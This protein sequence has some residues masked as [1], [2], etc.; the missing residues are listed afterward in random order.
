MDLYSILEAANDAG[1]YLYLE[2]GSLKFKA[3][4]D[5]FPEE[6]RKDITDN[7]EAII[8][9]LSQLEEQSGVAVQLSR[10]DRRGGKELFTLSSPQERL[11]TLAQLS[12]LG[13]SYNISS[14]LIW[15]GLFDINKFNQSIQMLIERHEIIRT[16]YVEDE[17]GVPWQVVRA[18]T[19]F[20][21]IITD[22]SMFK[23][24]EQQAQLLVSLEHEQIHEFDLKTGLMLRVAV[25][26]KHEFEHIVV[27]TMHHIASDGWSMEIARREIM[28]CYIALMN[29]KRP[30]LP[31]LPIQY[32]DYASWQ[33][34]LKESSAFDG[35]LA[36]WRE[37]LNEAPS[38]HSIQ[39]DYP[40]PTEKRYHGASVDYT[41]TGEVASRLS[42]LSQ[43]LQI[44][45]FMLLHAALGIVFSRHSNSSDII[46][47]TPV[48]GREH[49]NL[50]TLVGFFIN[51]L[52]L[53]IS[54]DYQSF[55]DYIGHVKK[56]H[57]DAH[58]NQDIPFESLV[59]AFSVKRTPSYMPIFQIML[60]TGIE[61]DQKQGLPNG[62]DISPF[63]LN[64]VHCKYDL[65]IYLSIGEDAVDMV[66]NYDISLFTEERVNKLALHL[67]NVLEDWS[68]LSDL[69]K[70]SLPDLTILSESERHFLINEFNDTGRYTPPD[71]CI[72]HLFEKQVAKTPGQI[73][74]KTDERQMTY[75]ELNRHAN[76]IARLLKE[77]HGVGP[78]CVVG[79]YAERSLEMVI[80][81]IA[82]LK[83]GGA[84]LPLDP[85]YPV[86]RLKFILEDAAL[87]IIVTANASLKLPFDFL[88]DV[89]SVESGIEKGVQGVSSKAY[90]DENLLAA[91]LSL[92]P[93]HLAYVIY[94]SGSTGQPKGVMVEHQAIVNRI[95]WMHQ[96]YGMCCCDKVLQKTPYSFDVSVWEFLWTLG[97]G[98]QLIMARPSG[99]K[100]PEYLCRLIQ[101]EGITK[102][103]FVPSMLGLILE[104]PQFSA[105]TSLQQVFCSGET[106]T[107][108][109]VEA[110]YRA[111]P[112]TQLYNLYGPT[113][114]AIDVSS[115]DCSDNN[116]TSVPIGK[117]IDN[118]QLFIL[119]DNMQLVPQGTVGELYIG[120]DGLARGYLNRK[121][122]TEKRFVDN[123]FY[124]EALHA[125]S[126]RL[127]RTGD[128]V[129]MRADGA[130]EY[131]GRTD[132]QIKIRGLR[133]ELGEIEYHLEQLPNVDSAQVIAREKYDSYQIIAYVGFESV[134][135]DENTQTQWR[136]TLAQ[137]LPEHMLPQHFV[138]MDEWPRTPNGK[139]D[140]K[141]L[142]E[143]VAAS[144]EVMTLPKTGTE[145]V[146]KNIWCDLLDLEAEQLS[147]DSNFFELGGHSLLGMRMLSL[148]NKRFSIEISVKEILRYQDIVSLGGLIDE[149]C[150]LAVENNERG[151]E[152]QEY[153][154]F[155]L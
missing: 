15:R 35:Q 44:T 116:N 85:E 16:N 40:R 77:Q 143:P 1:I 101:Q 122:L 128:L 119:N 3:R 150:M 65:E 42:R 102:L 152:E 98:G 62:Y 125:K 100:E 90:S 19:P 9:L 20:Q 46:V 130:I 51:N 114:A 47:G 24:T 39:L 55:L 110:F 2:Q 136:K 140:R 132:H 30:N 131:L 28:E 88:G 105:C 153:E 104:S 45:P 49:A 57:L 108:T 151:S 75:Q 148:V 36:Y 64:G 34:K 126:T 58:K 127:Y 71:L 113:E 80:G 69:T 89:V 155:S 124:Q 82:I 60:H 43:R 50:Q 37:Q 76:R 29:D 141:A 111:L 107:L 96:Q 91:E 92:T 54:T 146:L 8:K 41:L 38:L 81:L 123:P 31:I 18:P 84:Y 87:S 99:H 14:A 135:V 73:A 68:R 12:T 10:V 147:T 86:G 63:S 83:A 121:R 139:I 26:R 4:T 7:K 32:L 67:G 106:L 22:L 61:F 56:V 103:H 17:Q 94:T 5:E 23:E 74:I 78:D 149:V 154:D 133:V 79:L 93:K 117:P 97:Y 11:W 118:I 33:S 52:V 95:R 66:W 145:Q 137:S 112:E 59:N 70:V 25:I 6:L 134:K 144:P 115:W 13:A 109:Y 138:C 120:G 21:S 142:P 129:R 53:R 48:S 27:L 72:H